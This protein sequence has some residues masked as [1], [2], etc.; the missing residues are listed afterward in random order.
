[1]NVLTALRTAKMQMTNPRED[2]AV[3]ACFVVMGSPKIS[4]VVVLDE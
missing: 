3:P 4:N 2:N 1:M